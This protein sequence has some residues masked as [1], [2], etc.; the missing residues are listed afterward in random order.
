MLDSIN[1]VCFT[2]DGQCVL[3]G[4]LNSIIKLIDKETGECLAEY[5]VIFS[6]LNNLMLTVMLK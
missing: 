4:C 6:L 2:K 1:S 3:T 5:V